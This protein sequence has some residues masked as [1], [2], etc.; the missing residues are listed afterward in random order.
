MRLALVDA[1]GIALRLVLAHMLGGSRLWSVTA[2]P[3]TPA[4]KSIAAWRDALPT[5]TAFAERKAAALA[6][7]GLDGEAIVSDYASGALTTEILVKL[8]SLTDDDVLA[9][10]AVAMAEALAM[11]TALIDTLGATLA[12]DVGAHWQPDDLFFEVC[13][14]REAIGAM[15]SDVIG[16]AAARSYLTETGTRKKAIIRRALVG[17]GRTKVEGWLPH[18]MRFPMSGYTTR[19]M[20][21]RERAAA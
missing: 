20:L 8:M 4:N 2:E 13:R 10:L 7:L 14:D 21:A 17:D 16:D 9:L 12:V 19:P 11:G 18:Y 1:P 5:Q 6:T 3:Q 15:L